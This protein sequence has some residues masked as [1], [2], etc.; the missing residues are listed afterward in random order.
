MIYTR[1]Y[2]LYKNTR[3]IQD[4]YHVFIPSFHIT[5]QENDFWFVFSILFRK[6]VI[7]KIYFKSFTT[8]KIY[9]KSFT[10]KLWTRSTLCWLFHMFFLR[11]HSKTRR[12]WNRKTMKSRVLSGV[13]FLERLS[14]FASAVQ[15]R[16]QSSHASSDISGCDRLVSEL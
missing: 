7:P 13:Q 15:W 8:Q 9:F 14:L 1:I 5:W 16:Y 10:S 12:S 2:D 3:F 11:L 4:T 6:P